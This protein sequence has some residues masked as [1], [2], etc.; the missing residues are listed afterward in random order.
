MATLIDSYSESNQSSFLSVDGGGENYTKTG[1]SFTGSGIYLDSCK[2]YLRKFGYPTGNATASI[3]EHTGTYGTTGTGT[4]NALA[5]SETFNVST[6]TMTLALVTFSFTGANRILLNADTKYVV[7]VEYSGGNSSNQVWIGADNTSPTHDGN[8][9]RYY[10]YEVDNWDAVSGWDVCFYVYGESLGTPAYEDK[11]LYLSGVATSSATRNLYIQGNLTNS[12][13]RNL[14]LTGQLDGDYDRGIYL[15]GVESIEV[16]SG[17]YLI[18]KKSSTVDRGI[19]LSGRV[20]DY[21]DRGIYLTGANSGLAERG[22][23]LTGIGNGIGSYK[24]LTLNLDNS[25]IRNRVY[26][27]GSTKLSDFTTFSMVADGEQ[28]VFNLPD[29]P[30]EITMT[31][32]SVAKTIGIKN[33][34][35]PDDFDYLLNY[36]EKYI[37]CGS[38][39]APTEGLVVE[40]TYKYDIPIL[41]AIEDTDSIEEYG[42]LEYAIFNTDIKTTEQARARATA[43]LQDY[44]YPTYSGSFVTETIGFS[45]GQQMKIDISEL[46]I[47]VDFLVKSVKATSLGN[48]HFVY[49]ISI[50]SSR[51]LGIIKFLIGMLE[52]NKNALNISSDEVVD[53]LVTI[54]GESFT[55]TFGTP[56]L[57]THEGNYKYDSDAD[58]DTSEWGN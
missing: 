14:Y 22:F 24:N 38:A 21:A 8:V 58:W 32:D 36:Q 19:Y 20:L 18:G 51:K 49:T 30:H 56:I 10:Y 15:E 34:D 55:I 6:L 54:A 40:F 42:Q 29:K 41:V 48:G 12:A 1:Q 31:V 28:T 26:V 9:V 11:G 57:T 53:E 2:F 5:T 43:E 44:A 7:V 39:S 46:G 47:N 37:E 4:G 50:V 52:S 17:I 25:S 16:D 3:Y 33:I 27:R 35:D 13:D 45:A 23:Y